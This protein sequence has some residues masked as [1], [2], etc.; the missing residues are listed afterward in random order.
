MLRLLGEMGWHLWL[1]KMH[2]GLGEMCDSVKHVPWERMLHDGDL[3]RYERRGRGLHRR[4]RLLRDRRWRRWL[5][6]LHLLLHHLWMVVVVM[7]GKTKTHE[8]I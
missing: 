4:R 1:R 2:D 6:W 5:L 3:C 7:L 8:I